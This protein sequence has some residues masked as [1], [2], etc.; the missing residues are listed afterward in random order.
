MKKYVKEFKGNDLI[1]ETGDGRYKRIVDIPEDLDDPRFT[2]IESKFTFHTVKEELETD[3]N[4]DKL[5]QLP[6]LY[7]DCNLG[8]V[9]PILIPV[10]KI[11][12]QKD[13]EERTKRI[14]A[15]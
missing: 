8:D 1:Q 6:S 5:A 7:M 10:W 11:K 2:D 9:E 15:V 4:E 13:G 3:V 14:Q 12:Y